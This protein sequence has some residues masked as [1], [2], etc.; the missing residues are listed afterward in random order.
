MTKFVINGVRCHLKIYA[1]GLN[2]ICKRV[3][4]FKSMRNNYFCY[5]TSGYLMH[6]IYPQSNFWEHAITSTVQSDFQNVASALI[7]LFGE[8]GCDVQLYIKVVNELIF[9]LNGNQI[10][11]L[12]SYHKW[13]ANMMPQCVQ[14]GSFITAICSSPLTQRNIFQLP[15]EITWTYPPNTITRQYRGTVGMVGA[16]GGTKLHA[17]KTCNR[18]EVRNHSWSAKQLRW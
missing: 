2:T 4:K 13:H 14:E 18:N 5:W 9:V 3:G 1:Q 7:Q 15:Y 11:L 8:Y 6:W 12:S 16:V 10:N 17:L